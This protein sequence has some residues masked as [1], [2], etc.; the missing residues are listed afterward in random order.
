M[1]QKY[2]N[3]T[4][5][6]DVRYFDHDVNVSS[7]IDLTKYRLMT[8]DEIDRHENPEKYLTDDEKYQ[9]YLKTLT[10]L[11]RRQFKRVLVLNGYD[12]DAIRAKILEIAD[13]QLRQLTLI[14]W[15]DSDIFERLDSSLTMMINLLEL[16]DAQVNTMWEQAM[17][18]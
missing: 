8:D 10:P 9:N 12:L 17:A 3:L 7:W 1:N 15:D 13:T 6:S 5:G 14:D 16:S 11:T 18:L 2:I 4:D